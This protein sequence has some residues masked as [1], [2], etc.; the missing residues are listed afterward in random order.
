MEVIT[1]RQN[2]QIKAAIALCDKKGRR[3]SGL[4]RFDGV[5]LFS[6][7]LGK[8]DIVSVFL[9]TPVNDR[10]TEAVR[11]AVDGGYVNEKS[12]IYVSEGVF[13]KLTEENAPEGIVTVARFMNELHGHIEDTDAAAKALNGKCLLIAES[14]RDPGN[15]GTVIR[16]C[17]ALGIDS[18]IMTDD[19][20]DIYN[21]KTVRGAM[22]ALFR[23]PT[24]T[25]PKGEM[26][27]FVKSLIG[28]GRR[29]YAAALR[30]DAM[31]I[32]DIE[33]RG[34]DCFVIGNEGHG[35][36]DELIDA[37]TATAIIPMTE[38]SESLNAAA[39]ATI[40]IWETVKNK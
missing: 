17:A 10:V 40:C 11:R 26:P 21:P 29:V 32:G 33:L 35:L 25:V 6:D 31:R 37:C 34:K 19:C 36:S 2:P 38:G 28:E 5:K 27:A 20:A 4:F 12:V 22:G 39:A 13:E 14:L 24:L 30:D 15:L 16:S 1:S 3:S 8:A 7:A 18:L 23:L 9:K